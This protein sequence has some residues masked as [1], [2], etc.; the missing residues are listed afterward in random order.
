MVIP[1]I[2]LAMDNPDDRAFMEQ[3]YRTYRPLM[4]RIAIGILKSHHDAEDAINDACVRLIPKVEEL[5]EKNDYNLKFYIM[6]TIRNTAINKAVK[7]NR[8]SKY[9]FLEGDSKILD[10]VPGGEAADRPL[11]REA[12]LGALVEALSEMPANELNLLRMKYLDELPDL[13]IADTL[14]VKPASIRMYLT[15]AKRRAADL[16]GGEGA[17]DE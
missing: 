4:F 10:L 14:G 11:I 12:E 15:R 13:Q 9:S 2:I 17:R 16:L 1:Q 3:L 5:Q 6:S 7:R 8:N